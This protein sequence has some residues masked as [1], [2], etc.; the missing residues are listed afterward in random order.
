[1]GG[2]GC[3]AVS[4][5]IPPR[6]LPR[7]RVSLNARGAVGGVGAGGGAGGA[8]GRCRMVRAGAVTGA[9]VGTEGGLAD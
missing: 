1:M 4:R 8:G 6:P 7:P 3:E 5:E 2:K 9:G